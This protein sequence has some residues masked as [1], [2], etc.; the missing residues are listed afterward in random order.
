MRCTLL[1]QFRLTLTRLMSA[2]AVLSL[3]AA[4][5]RAQFPVVSDDLESYPLGTFGTVS[6]FSDATYLGANATANIVAG[7][8]L[9]FSFDVKTDLGA[10]NTNVS[11]PFP[12]PAMNNSSADISNYTLEFDAS[13]PSGLNTGWFGV[14]EVQ[15][16]GS[17]PRTLNL[18][19]GALAVGG[20][21]VHHSMNF[22]TMGQP[23]GTVVDPTQANWEYHVVA[24]GFPAN[25]GGGTVR[26]SL[27]ID[28]VRVT[29]AVPE[30][31]SLLLLGVASIGAWG[32]GRRPLRK[33][34]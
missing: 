17:G 34:S 15:T 26:T 30:P 12:A 21:P 32:F 9:E 6:D 33:L 2:V 25:G 10:L 31:A 7:Q 24:L 27:L 4:T 22:S 19:M 1:S 20:T 8:A 18:N 11:T 14:V 28:N 23:F 5:G 13:I 29:N 3:L 16:P